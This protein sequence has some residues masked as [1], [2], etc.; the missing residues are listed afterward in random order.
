VR[1][2]Q[3]VPYDFAEEGGVKRHA[4]HLAAA[5]RRAGDEVEIVAPLS[6]GDPPPYLKA[7]GG[8]V[9]V[10]A[11]GSANYMALFVSPWSVHRFL[12]ERRFDI[13][14]LHEP[15]VPMLAYYTLW[16]SPAAVHVATFHMYAEA[17]P[18]VSRM[19]RAA[20]AK[21]LFPFL[22]AGV[23]VSPAAADFVAPLWRRP[24]PIVPNGVPTGVFTPADQPDSAADEHRLRLLFVGNW[25]DSRKGLQVLLEACGRLSAKGVAFSLDVIGE[26]EPSENQRRVPGVTFHGSIGSE[27]AL[28]AHY[29]R[30]DVFV[31]PATGQESFGIVLLEAMACARPVVCSDIRGFRDVIHPDGAS[32]VAPGDPAAL[33]RAIADLARAPE[34][35]RAMGTLNRARAE[36]YDWERIADQIRN[37]YLDAISRRRGRR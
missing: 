13:V 32:V 18:A 9:N 24:L 16:L 1:I 31:A 2:C 10:P 28:A 30:S 11:N 33:E 15:M 22:E 29:R 3:V 17:E 21:F 6:R 37:F 19:A 12:R 27:E 5:L 14:H 4:L 36:S 8:V 20:L 34:R 7:F 35:W 23:A 25:R 26:G